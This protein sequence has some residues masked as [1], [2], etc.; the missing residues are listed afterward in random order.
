MPS[1]RRQYLP[2]VKSKRTNGWYIVRVKGTRFF[3]MAKYCKGTWHLIDDKSGFERFDIHF[4]Y[5][6][7]QCTI[8][9]FTDDITKLKPQSL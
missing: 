3:T 5:I 7:D 9:Q 8:P 4:D 2:P 6:D 1:A